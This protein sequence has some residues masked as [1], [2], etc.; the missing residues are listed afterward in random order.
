MRNNNF[1]D[2]LVK[3]KSAIT[4]MTYVTAAGGGAPLPGERNGEWKCP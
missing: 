4:A 1:A 3:P 2:F